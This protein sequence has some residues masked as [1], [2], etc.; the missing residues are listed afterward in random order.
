M[1]GEFGPDG[2]ACRN[3]VEADAVE[4][5]LNV[6][7]VRKLDLPT[8]WTM[9]RSA[10]GSPERSYLR[11]HRNVKTTWGGSIHSLAVRR[12]T[13]SFPLILRAVNGLRH[14][15]RFAAVAHRESVPCRDPPPRGLG[16]A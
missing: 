12:F 8:G 7:L 2:P 5:E 10:L 1:P 6:I 15:R 3:P 16:V 14:P 9:V 4:I 13:P 11:P